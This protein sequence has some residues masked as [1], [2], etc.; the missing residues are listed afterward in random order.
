MILNIITVAF[1]LAMAYVWYTQGVFSAMVH[2]AVVIASGAIALAVWEPLT[3][4]L[5]INWIPEFAWTAG[6]IGPFFLLT[7]VLRTLSNKYIPQRMHQHGLVDL[8]GGAAC[9]AA[10]G[11][12][13]GGFALIGV[14]MLKMPVAIAGMQ[15]YT[16]AIDGSIVESDSKLWL[17]VDTWTVNFYNGL[18]QGAFGSS[19]PLATH[20]PQLDVQHW[21]LRMRDESASIVATPET[22]STVAMHTVDLSSVEMPGVVTAALSEAIEVDGAGGKLVTVDTTWSRSDGAYDS[23]SYARIPQTHVRLSVEIDGQ[24]QMISPVASSKVVDGARLLTPFDS[25]DASEYAL[26]TNDSIA[27]SF[28]VPDD[29]EPQF[30]FIRK[31]RLEPPAVD[32]SQPAEVHFAMLGEPYLAPLEEE[33]EVVVEDT[34]IENPSWIELTN[35]LPRMFGRSGAVG[36]SWAPDDATQVYSGHA[37]IPKGSDG[38]PRTRVRGIYTPSLSEMVRVQLPVERAASFYGK[39]RSSAKRLND[40]AIMATNGAA[41]QATAWVLVSNGGDQEVH[42]DHTQPIRNGVNLP[43]TKMGS[44]DTLYLYFLV[45]KGVTLNAFTSGG[46]TVDLDLNI[47]R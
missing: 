30:L 44:G 43:I 32:E 25:D 9:G 37:E 47:P 1:V 17:P 26:S 38:G 41:F 12:I 42:V 15:P 16:T 3:L 11:V 36:L 33:V 23:D 22:V 34:G 2:L 19:T 18:S 21:L 27:F 24:T 46:D 4:G 10:A 6:L 40:I 39:A 35:D 8:F 13:A 28:V 7:M 29:A 45:D 5:L 31:L 14:G 20:Q